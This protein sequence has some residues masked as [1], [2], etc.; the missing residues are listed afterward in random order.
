VI[1]LLIGTSIVAASLLGWYGHRASVRIQAWGEK[2][3]EQD[4]IFQSVASPEE[5][6][7]APVTRQRPSSPAASIVNHPLP[8]G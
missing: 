2:M 1:A 5:M 8:I 4:A 7:G 3:N 6:A